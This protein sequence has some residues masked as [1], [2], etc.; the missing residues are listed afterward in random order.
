MR[1]IRYSN[2]NIHKKMSNNKGLIIVTVTVVFTIIIMITIV[3]MTITI[4]TYK[5][6]KSFGEGVKAYYLAESGVSEAYS[7]LLTHSDAN[8]DNHIDSNIFSPIYDQPHS[9]AWSVSYDSNS[10]AYTITSTGT[11]KRSTKELLITAQN[12]LSKIKVTSWNQ[13]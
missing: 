7:Y 8:V 4:N 2:A 11:Y 13:Q 9:I 3:L 12:V 5:T 1:K 6:S 10:T